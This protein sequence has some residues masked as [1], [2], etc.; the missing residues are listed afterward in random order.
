MTSKCRETQANLQRN[1]FLLAAALSHVR[2]P[3]K[4]RTMVLVDYGGGVGDISLLAKELGIG[5]VIYNDIYGELA[6]DAHCIASALNLVADHYVASDETGLVRYL[7]SQAIVPDIVVSNDAIE[8]IY[9]VDS[10]LDNID[11][12]SR[13]LF[14]VIVATGAN[15]RNFI[16][17][18]RLQSLQKKMEYE[19][20]VRREGEDPRDTPLAYLPLRREI[21]TKHCNTISPAEVNTLAERTRGMRQDDI[22]MAATEY[23]QNGQLPPVADHPTNTCDPLWG[24]WCERLIDPAVWAARLSNMGFQSRILAGYY[25]SVPADVFL[26]RYARAAANA[27]ISISGEMGVRLAPFYCIVAERDVV[28]NAGAK[29]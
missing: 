22:E 17:R 18:R 29:G 14:R 8:H 10:F 3:Q 23:A 24:N 1:T 21:I 13:G 26:K 9:S 5:T 11:Q 15:P 6:K 12:M 27:V 28:V 20:T 4:L 2:D 16:V 25:G 7:T 19:G